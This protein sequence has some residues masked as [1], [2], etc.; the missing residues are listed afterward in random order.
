MKIKAIV[1][2]KEIE[3]DIPESQYWIDRNNKR[4]S[5]YWSKADNLEKR[6]NKEFEK[7]YKELEKELYTFAGKLGEDTLTYSQKRV[8]ELMKEIKPY[9]DNLYEVEQL[10]LT[11]HLIEI[12]KDNYYKGLYGLTMGTKVAYNFVGIN[13]NA[14]K[15]AIQF[16][17]SGK[18]FSDRIYNNKTKLIQ[19]L[20]TELTQSMI[21]GDSIKET[22]KVFSNRLNISKENAQRLVQ[23]ETGA[24]LSMSDKKMYEE[25]G[26]D[27]YEYVATL[28]DRTSTTCKE[29]DNR[30]FKL[31]NYTPGLNAPPM[32]PRCRST[33][34]P[35]FSENTTKRMARDLNTGKSVVVEDISYNEWFNKYV[36]E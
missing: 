26:L 6:M 16:P 2:G 5:P 20:R 32:H 24:V 35:Y 9:I 29:L 4:M 28:D 22:A 19:T 18:N 3:I 15:T 12:Y 27:E 8:I 11:D 34:V 7:V 30:V 31:D 36:E 14:I 25:F 17:W 13:E 23:T 21:R 33:T 10:S 1:K